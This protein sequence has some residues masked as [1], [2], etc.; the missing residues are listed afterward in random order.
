MAASKEGASFR[1]LFNNPRHAG[2]KGKDS[3]DAEAAMIALRDQGVK[4]QEIAEQPDIPYT[5]VQRILS[6]RKGKTECVF[7]SRSSKERKTG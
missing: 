7:L 3:E 2:R 1:P 4:R 6:E 5:M